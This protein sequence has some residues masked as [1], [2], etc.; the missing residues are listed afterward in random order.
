MN[1]FL[2]CGLDFKGSRARS[3][4]SRNV[5]IAEKICIDAVG[6]SRYIFHH[7]RK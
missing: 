2:F 3:L 6:C 5:F 7:G 1:F 4:E